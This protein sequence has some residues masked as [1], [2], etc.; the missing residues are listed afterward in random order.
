MACATAGATGVPL[1]SSVIGL[2]GTTRSTMKA[3]VAVPRMTTMPQS[4]FVAA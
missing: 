4:T 2:P 1:S 3:T